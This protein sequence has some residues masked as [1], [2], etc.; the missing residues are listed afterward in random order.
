[1][2]D[3]TRYATK[4]KKAWTK[5]RA[6]AGTTDVPEDID[7]IRAM[8]LGILGVSSSETEAEKSIHRLL[9]TFVDWNEVRVSHP[10]EIQEALGDS[11]TVGSERAQ[12]LIDALQ[13]VYDRENVVS[14]ESFRTM[15]RRDA[16]QALEK[17]NG[18]DPYSVAF[19]VLWALGGHAIPVNDKLHKKLTTA[20]LVHPDAN[21]AE[22]Q[23]FLERHVSANEARLFSLAMR[24]FDG[25]ATSKSRKK[26]KAKTK[27]KT[28]RKSRKKAAG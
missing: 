25:A 4:L 18:M 3:G 2:K 11:S 10:F 26:T 17:L 1:M 15:G 20:E 24:T 19:V 7:P 9:Q 6:A 8:A 23:A 21:R 5:H 27:S 16:R 22:V 28:S 14:L 12:R 13:A